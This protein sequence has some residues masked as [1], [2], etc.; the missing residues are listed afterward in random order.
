MVWGARCYWRLE[1]EEGDGIDEEMKEN[2]L[3]KG[4]AEFC[5]GVEKKI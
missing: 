1:M 2:F 4:R 5:L 3:L